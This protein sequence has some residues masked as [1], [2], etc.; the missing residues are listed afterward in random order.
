MGAQNASAQGPSQRFDGS[1]QYS[2]QY[3]AQP[4]SA[5]AGSEA[6]SSASAPQSR[7]QQPRAYA[8]QSRSAFQS[9]SQQPTANQTYAPDANRPGTRYGTSPQTRSAGP[10][11]QTPSAIPRVKPST[12]KRKANKKRVAVTTLVVVLVLLLA[13]PTWLVWNTNRSMHHI[14]VLSASPG[15]SGTT[16]LF[17]GSDSRD[18]WNPDDPTEGER[19][20]SVI[21]V[22]RARNGQTAMVSM[23]RDLYVDIP[24][25]GMN[26]LNAS[27]AYGGPT[28]LVETLENLTGL[29]VDHYV[30]IGMT[31]VG[32]IIDALGG[33]ELCWDQ[34]VQDEF[35]GMDW[36]AGCHEVDGEEALA[37]SR[38]RYADP[39]GD[40]GRTMRQRQVLSAVSAKA[41]SP[42]VLF[43]PAEQLR[44]SETAAEALTVDD[45]TGVFTVGKLLLAMRKA[46]SAELTGQPPISSMGEST[47]V[48]SVMLLDES[49]APHFFEALRN[50]TLTPEDFALDF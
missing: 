30:Q 35:S 13:W 9:P 39:L 5:P 23:P 1:S 40:V 2:S 21:L 24:G 37:F 33:V 43:N 38:M 34:T 28:L 50:G 4:A 18:G 26:K 32:E 46:S 7:G 20:D 42:R 25:V 31:G 10:G 44:L 47:N 14:D 19:S 16:Y 48:G 22:H 36:V 12:T 29:T 11:P 6:S 27:F 15:T 45:K 49:K 17:A 41:L 8:P 3:P